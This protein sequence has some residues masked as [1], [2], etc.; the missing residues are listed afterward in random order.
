MKRR[1]IVTWLSAVLIAGCAANSDGSDNVFVVQQGVTQ[2]GPASTADIVDIGL[3]MLHNMTAHAVT[4]RWVR[5]A[6]HVRGMRV[7]NVTAYQYSEAGEGIAA[8]LGDLRKHCRKEM[9]PYPVTR[10][11]TRAHADSNWL[12]IIAITFSR[13]G[14]YTIR[15]AKIGYRTDGHLGWQYQ[16]LDTTVNVH[17]ANPGARPAL[18]GC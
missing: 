6:G 16:N 15:R 17:E 10:A 4:L 2:G 3:P 7:L 12:I 9:T 5:L 18:S 11:V 14:R 1:A 8:D 13:P